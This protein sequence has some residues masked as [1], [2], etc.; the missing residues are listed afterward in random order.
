MRILV[1]VLLLA[2]ILYAEQAS[3]KN[4]SISGH[5]KWIHVLSGLDNNYDPQTGST[6]GLNLKY[7]TPKFEGLYGLVGFHYVGDTGLT[8]FS[9]DSSGAY[10]KKIASGIFMTKDYSSKSVLDEA[11]IAYE[12]GKNL[13]KFG[14]KHPP[15]LVNNHLANPIAMFKTSHVDNAYESYSFK[16]QELP[17]TTIRLSQMTKMMYGCEQQ[18][19]TH[20]S[21]NLLIQLALHETL[22]I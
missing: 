1:I 5:I 17:D 19:T 9:K 2:T 21:V 15:V 14:R 18:L 8:D 7:Q 16:T 4:G 3:D 12:I 22:L 13:F 11:W 10:K 6:I 20:L